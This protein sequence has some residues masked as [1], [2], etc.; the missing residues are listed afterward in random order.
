MCDAE[1]RQTVVVHAHSTAQPAIRVVGL[2]QSIQ[3]PRTADTLAGG[4]QPQRKHQ[5]RAGRGLPRRMPA[6]PDPF[7]QLP[8]IELLDVI[9]YH[10]C[11]MP[12]S[13]HGLQIHRP[14]FDLITHRFAQARRAR[15]GFYGVGFR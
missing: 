14:K 15:C 8:Q 4:K 12:G 13:E 10:P 3:C 2:A 6:R 7:L 1:V 5:A 9:P 11:R